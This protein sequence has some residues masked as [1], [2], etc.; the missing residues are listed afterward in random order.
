MQKPLLGIENH[1]L[2]KAFPEQDLFL[3]G[4]FCFSP[5]IVGVKIKT[6][7]ATA[8]WSR[9]SGAVGKGFFFKADQIWGTEFPA[10]S[11]YHQP[12]FTIPELCLLL[13]L[14]WTYT[15]SQMLYR[16]ITAPWL[17]SEM[18]KVPA[19]KH[20]PRC[21]M[22]QTS[23]LRQQSNP[24]AR[25]IRHCIRPEALQVRRD[26]VTCP[27]V[28]AGAVPTIPTQRHCKQ[29]ARAGTRRSWASLCQIDY[30]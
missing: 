30:G 15:S 13:L 29:R 23:S 10:F 1:F 28:P 6:V 14:C 4:F 11:L 19:E 8:L 21:H 18:S 20:L 12:Y 26:K 24:L 25:V 5:W 16:D 9:G 3:T 22:W 7:V 2:C 27:S 17:S